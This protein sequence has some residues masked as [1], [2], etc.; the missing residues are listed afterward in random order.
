MGMRYADFVDLK[1]EPR[2]T[3]VT[4]TF[5]LEPW[6]I[7]ME[8]ASGGVAAESSIGTWTELTTVKPYVQR[9]RA[10]VFHIEGNEAKIAYPVE[11]FEPGNMPNILSSVAGNIFGLAAVK[12]L[13]LEDVQFPRRLVGGFLG[14]AYGIKGVRRILKVNDRPLV[15]TIIKPKLGLRS[16][17]HANVAYEAWRGGCDLVKDDENLASQRFNSFEE[18]VRLTLQ[19]RDRAESET[20]EKKVYMPN[21]TAEAEEMLRRAELVKELGGTHA[22]IDIITCGFSGFQALRKKNLGLVI[23][24]HRA[25]HA[26]FTR[27]ASHGIAMKVV[28]KA[29]R[30][31]GADQ[32]HVGTVVGKMSETKKEVLENV[33]AIKEPLHGLKPVF[34]VASG[35]LHPGLVPELIEIFGKDLII[36]AGG[37]IHGHPGGTMKGSS[38]L[39]QAVDAVVQAESLA[40]YAKTHQ[41][42]A[43]ALKT[44]KT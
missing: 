17:D 38:A 42:L 15:G 9:L 7:S 26:A 1:Y 23:H 33:E 11:L 27:I 32:L 43:L 14:P 5:K 39:R 24:A 16:R 35:G 31:V 22:M 8:E 21:V 4:C 28:A 2:E 6:G 40:E 19:M 30:I 34:P 12:H 44:W 20:G 36:Q 13:R 18:R 25:G 41:D 10:T 29:A 37:G 3:E